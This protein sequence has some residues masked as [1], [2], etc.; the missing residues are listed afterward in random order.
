[1]SQQEKRRWR[2]LC[3]QVASE[4]DPLKL[5]N[6]FLE[7]DRIVVEQSMRMYKVPRGQRFVVREQNRRLHNALRRRR[8]AQHK[9]KKFGAQL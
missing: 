6:M 1:M 7:L 3:S 9:S 4:T 2:E 8:L 5:L